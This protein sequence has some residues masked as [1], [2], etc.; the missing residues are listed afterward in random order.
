MELD[1]VRKK[2]MSHLPGGLKICDPD[3]YKV[4][5]NAYLLGHKHTMCKFPG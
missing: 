1:A 4:Q 2:K 5:K 3:T